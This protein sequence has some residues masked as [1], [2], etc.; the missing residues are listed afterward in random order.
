MEIGVSVILILLMIVI[1]LNFNKHKKKNFIVASY[2][3]LVAVSIF[4]GIY[5][6]NKYSI[7][8]YALAFISSM[9]ALIFALK[10]QKERR[11]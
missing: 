6:N 4:P 11:A 3:I 8:F 7:I 2:L 9:I 10:T 1:G 5:F